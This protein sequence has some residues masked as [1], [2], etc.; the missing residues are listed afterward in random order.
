VISEGEPDKG[1]DVRG[2]ITTRMEISY[3]GNCDVAG[4]W[5]IDIRISISSQKL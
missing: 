4:H 2:D 5:H 3:L 1:K